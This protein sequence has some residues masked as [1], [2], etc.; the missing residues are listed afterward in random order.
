MSE[1]LLICASN[2][3]SNIL[4]AVL[5]GPIDIDARFC[6]MTNSEDHY[7]QDPE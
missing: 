1:E 3:E 5:K 6:H 2:T 4:I 7:H